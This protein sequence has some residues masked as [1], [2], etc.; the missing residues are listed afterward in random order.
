MMRDVLTEAELRALLGESGDQDGAGMNAS[1]WD[2]NDRKLLHALV[3]NQL[4][5]LHMIEEMQAELRMLKAAA[6]PPSGAGRQLAAALEPL[7]LPFMKQSAAAGRVDDEA[8][9]DNAP[10]AEA[11]R[12]E[13]YKRKSFW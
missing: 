2:V 12:K 7:P 13:R 4:R 11:S 6:M 9:R 8:E 5:L 1:T 10:S 3:R